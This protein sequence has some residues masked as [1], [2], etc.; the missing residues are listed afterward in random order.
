MKN[1]IALF[2]FFTLFAAPFQAQAAGIIPC[3]GIGQSACTLCD[4]FRLGNNIVSF[5]LFPTESNNYIPVVALIAGLFIVIGGFYLFIG[6]AQ[7]EYQRKGKTVLYSVVI[8]LFIVYT[9]WVI[10]ESI[11]AFMGVA[12]WTGLRSWWQ[13][14]CK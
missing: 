5:F 3:G 7:P 4:L 13:I 10:I 11:L 8:G 9:A 1:S 2:L 12:E 6:G 14:S